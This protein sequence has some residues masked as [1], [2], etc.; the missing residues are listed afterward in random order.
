[1]EEDP[2]PRFRFS[3]NLATIAILTVVYFLA[4]KLGLRLAFANPSA[5]AVWP[6]TGIA[7]AAFVVIG[8][9]VWPGIFLGAFLTNLATAGSVATSF[10][11]AVGNTLEGMLGAYLINRF[12][13]GRRIFD[14]TQDVFKFACLAAMI[15]T[16]VS[17]T[18]GVTSLAIAGFAKWSEYR[19]IWLTWWLGDAAGDLVV[20]PLLILWALSV[21]VAS[22]KWRLLEFVLLLL[23]L[24]LMGQVVFGG[25]FP[26][27]MTNYPLEFLCF[28]IL[29][30]AAFRFGQRE[31]ATAIFLLSGIAIWGTLRGF[32]PFVQPKQNESLLLLQAFMGVTAVM[33]LALATLVSER[34]RAEANR[35]N[36]VLDLQGALSRIKTLKG[37]LPICS[38]CKKIRDDKGYWNHMES[39][40]RHHSEADFTHGICPSCAQKL[41][42]EEHEKAVEESGP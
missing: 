5:T 17:A 34:K 18:G 26:S 12:A 23:C 31:A 37:L 1:M 33:I 22:S 9:W 36:L 11:I 38:V 15:S 3:R 4:G 2:V 39:Y 6:P 24:F 25:V 30:W 35:E 29:I 28:P 40:I 14:R 42:P 27:G 20:A 21:R 13:G 16:L 10:S 19:A 41:Y 7:L 32:G 8:Y